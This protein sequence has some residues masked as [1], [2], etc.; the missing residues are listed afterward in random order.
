MRLIIFLA[1]IC[2]TLGW[3]L[4]WI[5]PPFAGS[6]VS[7]MAM[8]RDGRITLGPDS[9]WQVWVFLGGFAAAALAALIALRGRG[10]GIFALVAGVSPLVVLGDAL[11]R[12]ETL[13]RDLGLPFPVDL[14]DLYTSWSLLRDFLRIGFWAYVAGAAVL[15]LAGASTVFTRRR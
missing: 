6:A 5:D 10:A 4:T 7:P 14:G 13:R 2:M 1:G 11:I 12:A 3:G 9:P 8:V 15:L